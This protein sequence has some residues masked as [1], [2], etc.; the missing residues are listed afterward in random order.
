MQVR[1]EALWTYPVKSLAGIS[2]PQALVTPLGLAYD[3]HWMLIDSKGNFVSQRT[4]PAMALIHT[5]LTATH[6]HLHTGNDQFAIPLQA[7]ATGAR[8]SAR[9]WQDTCEVSDEGDAVSRWLQQYLPSP[10]PLR[11]V[12]MAPGFRRPQSAGARFGEHTSTLFADAAPCLV[13]N[14]ASLAALN[15][16]LT[17]NTLTPVDMRRFRP[18]IVISGLPA[19]AEQTTA[20]LQS[21]TGLL[22]L[23]DPSSRCVMTTVD[24]DTGHKDPAQEPFKTLARLNPM[25]DRPKM[26]AFGMNTTLQ[27]AADMVLRCGDWLT[28]VPAADH[29]PR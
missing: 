25:A 23:C 19:F 2:L 17:R 20:S 18:N 14:T 10:Q 22:N 12:R 24:P 8:L 28:A 7:N 16:E 11:L 3:R 13:A 21:D 6:L 4:L 26:P 27:A 1:I 15:E 29:L 9:V 5:S